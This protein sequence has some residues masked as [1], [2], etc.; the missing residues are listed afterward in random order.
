MRLSQGHLSLLET[1]PRHF[2][3]QILDQL[4]LKSLSWEQE[5]RLRS[6]SEFHQ[7][8]QQRSLQ[9]PIEMLLTEDSQ[10]N[11]WFRAFENAEPT[12][13]TAKLAAKDE[14]DLDEADLDEARFAES[15]HVRTIA[16]LGHSLV[17]VYDYVVLKSKTALILDW[18]TY[19]KPD[20]SQS[21]R[22][23]WQSRLYPY[24]LH[25]SS[26]Y[27]AD[28]I[29]MRY[30]FFQSDGTAQRLSLPYSHATHAETDR[31]LTLLLIQLNHWLTAYTDHGIPFPQTQQFDHCD[32]CDHAMR[33]GRSDSEA[34]GLIQPDRDI[35]I[36]WEQIPEVS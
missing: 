11:R 31:R 14:T 25:E 7:I 29:E 19:G 24:V 33:C 30:W 6:G 10:L 2:Q 20:R 34:L 8:M 26:H 23:S 32:R 13:F 22:E 18:K 5:E 12:L 21:I 28:H 27:E 16:R 17:V 4:S 9:L 15:E 1:C 35:A 3:H 36:D